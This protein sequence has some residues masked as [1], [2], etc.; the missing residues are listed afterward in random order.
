MS[1]KAES[2]EKEGTLSGTMKTAI[3]QMLLAEVAPMLRMEMQSMDATQRGIGN[4]AGAPA[5][6]AQ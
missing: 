3:V 4:D 2:V 5:R 6:L 1:L